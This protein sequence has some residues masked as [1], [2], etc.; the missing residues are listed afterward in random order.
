MPP[1]LDPSRLAFA[2]TTY[3][4]RASTLS[5]PN[6]HENEIV[7]VMGKLGPNTGMEVDP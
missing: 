3:A 5:D 7:A 2:R 6:L 4:F 1:P